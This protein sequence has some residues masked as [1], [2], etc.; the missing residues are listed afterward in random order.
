MNI[1]KRIWIFLNKNIDV[2]VFT[3]KHCGFNTHD[4]RT[5]RDLVSIDR[6]QCPGCKRTLNEIT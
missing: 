1:L 3:C 5:V 6:N 2:P 4:V